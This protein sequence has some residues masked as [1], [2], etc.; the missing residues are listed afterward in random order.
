MNKE[1]AKPAKDEFRLTAPIL[2]LSIDIE[3]S[4]PE[5]TVAAGSPVELLPQLP[6]TLGTASLL[7]PIAIIFDP[8]FGY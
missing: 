8:Q 7:E 1:T 2:G 4:V 6:V 3:D 5:M